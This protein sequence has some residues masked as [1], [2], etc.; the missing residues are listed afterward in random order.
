MTPATRLL[1]TATFALAA[2]AI[3][4][5]QLLDQTPPEEK[6]AKAAFEAIK[7]NNWKLFTEHVATH[8]DFIMKPDKEANPLTGGHTMGTAL[9]RAE[10]MDFLHAEFDRAA[11]GG[12]NLVDFKRAE[13]VS[14]GAERKTGVLPLWTEETVNYTIYSF[15][16]RI[17]GAEQDTAGSW[18]RFMMV[19]YEGKPKIFAIMFSDV[20]PTLFSGDMM[21]GEPGM[22]QPGE[23]PE[24]DDGSFDESP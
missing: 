20:L 13:F 5:C 8:S 3:V 14:L 24:Y 2:V 19:K 4:G 18:P 22:M 10:E 6:A 9:I 23:M 11:K 12:E 16:V 7:T 15:R 17:N 1:R 21:F